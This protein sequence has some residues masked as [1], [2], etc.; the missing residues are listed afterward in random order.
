MAITTIGFENRPEKTE[1]VSLLHRCDG[2]TNHPMFH[3]ASSVCFDAL[4]FE[5]DNPVIFFGMAVDIKKRQLASMN[6]LQS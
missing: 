1:A 6:K 3:V 4:E 5:R 2:K